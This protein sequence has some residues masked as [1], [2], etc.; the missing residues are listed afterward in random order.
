MINSVVIMHLVTYGFYDSLP[1]GSMNNCVSITTEFLL[2][3]TTLVFFLGM[4]DTN[5]I[6]IK[7]VYRSF[8]S[9]PFL[10]VKGSCSSLP[11]FH[12]I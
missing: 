1:S 12:F 6:F 8:F 4:S 5:L 10:V 7:M 11:A 3:P 2:L 9:M